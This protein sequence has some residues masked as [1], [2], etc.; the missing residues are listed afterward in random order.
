MARPLRLEFDGA[1]YHVTSRG[2]ERSNVFAAKAD[3]ERFLEKLAENV[4]QHHLRL[5][6]YVVMTN[7]F[8]LLVETPR[9]NL[10]RFMQQLN[11]SYTM[12]YNRKRNR[13][14]HVFSG[15]Y[16]AKLVSGDEYLL[17]LTRYLHLNPVKIAS[18]GSLPLEEKVARLREYEWSSYL[19]Y[20]G[21]RQRLKWVDYA[22]LLELAGQ[23][24][25]QR[26]EAYRLLVESGLAED[27]EDLLEALNRSSKAVG[28]VAFCRWAE[29]EHKEARK[30]VGREADV[31]MRRVECGEDPSVI[32]ERVCR[33]FEVGEE[34]LTQRRHMTDSRLITAKL[35]K[36]LTGLNQREIGMHVGL[37]DGSGLG[38]LLGLADRRMAASRRL[39][40]RYELLRR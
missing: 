24:R 37:K 11:T 3:K 1:I 36:E 6:A 8:H 10:T 9:A 38:H 20:A 22:P 27:D 32:V 26:E 2:N 5:Y 40:S 17:A 14:G 15:R 29:A 35:L 18:C 19:A 34:V 39:R 28:G 33:A 31:S 30:Q 13:V 21:L 23:G 7:H 4:E 12:Y 25:G 16:K